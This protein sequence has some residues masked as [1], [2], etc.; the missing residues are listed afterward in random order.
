MKVDLMRVGTQTRIRFEKVSV[1]YGPIAAIQNISFTAQPG[2]IIGL[3]GHNGAGKSTLV[4]V[5]CGVVAPKSGSIMINDVLVSDSPSPRQM[6]RLGIH[7]VHQEP[8]VCLNLSV[9]DNL[10]LGHSKFG[11]RH[12]EIAKAASALSQVGLPLDLSMPTRALGLG[13][14]QLLSIARGLLE[15][16]PQVLFLD[17]P[18][19][20]L[21]QA[22]AE[23]LHQLVYDLSQAGVTIFYVSHRLRDVA[24][25]CDRFLILRD[26]EL[27]DD[28]P[29]DGFTPRSL[30]QTL[31]GVQEIAASTSQTSKNGRVLLSSPRGIEVREG[32]I[33][34][35]FGMAGAEQFEILAQLFGMQPCKGFSW[36][37]QD[38]QPKSPR[39]AIERGVHMVQA[40]REQDS[41]LSNMNASDNVLI[42]WWGN[43][44]GLRTSGPRNKN[45]RSLYAKS[46]LL[47]GIK[48]PSSDAPIG[49][50][51]GGNRQ[52]HVLSRWIV[53][54]NPQLLLLAQPTQGID[55]SSKNE[56]AA[57]LREIANTGVPIL[58]ASAESD[59]IS[60]ICDRA[61][62]LVDGH[63]FAESSGD[64]FDERLLSRLLTHSNMLAKK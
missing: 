35:L 20:S 5:A 48:G 63:C 12:D 42:P 43:L 44:F 34:G 10:L 15:D 32:E 4:N 30:A 37:G 59:E 38:Y 64:N 50:F 18:A 13:G 24:E 31:T 60:R 61:Y 29:M 49:S 47:F 1:N 27:V 26:G 51:S 56:I 11:H 8:A 41:L 7:V 39:Q 14:R 58:V 45:A 23:R 6:Q 53:P 21:G 3:L 54:K 33:V 9:A 17:E 57:A 40:D 25:V 46:R 19:A 62:V 55:E 16:K 28:Q 52:K 22:D 36:L 2:E